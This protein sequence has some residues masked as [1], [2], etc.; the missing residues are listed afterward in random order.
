MYVL[1]RNTA[2]TRDFSSLIEHRNVDLNFILVNVLFREK[3][4][5]SKRFCVRN[6][7]SYYDSSDGP[8]AQRPLPRALNRSRSCRPLGDHQD[9]CNEHAQAR[10]ARWAPYSQRERILS[11]ARSRS[12][13]GPT[14]DRTPED[15]S[16]SQG[17]DHQADSSTPDQC[18]QAVANGNGGKWIGKKKPP[19]RRSLVGLGC[20]RSVNRM[21]KTWANKSPATLTRY[22][23]TIPLSSC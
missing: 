9:D 16:S 12:L 11:Q 21:L 2:N 20:W 10:P 8:T 3:V 18:S 23:R 22:R 5:T 4:S 15:W 17:Q 13:K 1:D 7:G 14:Q 19:N 6:T